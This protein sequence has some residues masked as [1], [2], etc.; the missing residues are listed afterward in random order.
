MLGGRLPHIVRAT[1]FGPK[2]KQELRPLTILGTDIGPQDDLIHALTK[3][4]IREKQEKQ[5]GWEVRALG[6]KILINSGSYGIYVEVNRKR[7]AGEATVHGLNTD[8]FETDETELEGPG[9]D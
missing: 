6:L 2:G 4:R 1:T 5:R 8:P 7:K 3:A 9:V